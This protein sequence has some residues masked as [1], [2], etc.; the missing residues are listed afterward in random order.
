MSA[1]PSCFAAL[2]LGDPA[3]LE[4]L[5]ARLP[6]E[7]RRIHPLDLHLTVAYF[8]RVDPGL[9]D[10]LKAAIDAVPWAPRVVEL[11]EL[12]VLPSRERC[13]AMAGTLGHGR[14][15]LEEFLAEHRDRLRGLAGLP[16]EGREPL[17]HVTFARPR[18]NKMN[19][20][21]RAAILGWIDGEAAVGERI[22]LTGFVLMRS[23]PPGGP[24]P[25]YEV[26]RS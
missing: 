25:F 9:H 6:P 1:P 26:V 21:K 5:H 18:G 24:G 17:P 8:G 11:G 7:L 2:R 22:E 23:L 20:A 16:P 19:E 15:E 12:V 13:S 14:S 3:P 4:R 10:V